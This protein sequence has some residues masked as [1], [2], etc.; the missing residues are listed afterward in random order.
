MANWKNRQLEKWQTGKWPTGK[1][2]NLKIAN[3]KMANRKN[4]QLE[5]KANWK[6]WPT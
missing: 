2:A 3:W 1:M 6:K 4:G 5:K